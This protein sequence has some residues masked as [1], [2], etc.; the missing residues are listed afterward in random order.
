MTKKEG[1]KPSFLKLTLFAV[2]NR[3]RNIDLVFAVP[4]KRVAR[5]GNIG[6]VVHF[7]TVVGIQLACFKGTVFNGKF[8]AVA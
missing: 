2:G 1:L 3:F 8:D 6:G 5:K 4:F 7:D